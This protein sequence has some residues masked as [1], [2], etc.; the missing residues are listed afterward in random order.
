MTLETVAKCIRIKKKSKSAAFQN[1]Q[2]GDIVHFS[3]ELSSAGCGS[4]GG[5][6]AK[7]ITCHNMRTDQISILSFNQLDRI[8]WNFEFAEHQKKFIPTQTEVNE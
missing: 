5:T 3:C 6:C 7:Y 1:M 8:L 4:G 2:I